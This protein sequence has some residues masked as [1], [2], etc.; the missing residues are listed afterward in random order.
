MTITMP[1]VAAPLIL[2]AHTAEDLMVPNPISMRAEASVT[3]ALTLFTEKG[4]AAAPVIDEAGR[5]IGVVSRSDLL[6]HQCEYEKNRSGQHDYFYAPT[7]TTGDASGQMKTTTTVADLMT[8][9]VFA[10]SPDTPVQRVV[11]DMI[12]LHVHRL[13]VVDEDGIL[14]GVISTMDVLKQLK[15]EE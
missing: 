12:G 7:F 13:F 2:H 11:S 6:I 15:A 14:V 4:I 5:P 3:E 1:R 9:A 8:P 10:V